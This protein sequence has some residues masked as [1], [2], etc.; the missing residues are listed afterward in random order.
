M[1]EH[2]NATWDAFQTH[3]NSKDVIHT[4]ISN[5]LPKAASDENTKLNA[6]KQH[7]KQGCIF[8]KEQQMNQ[9]Y[10]SNAELSDVNNIS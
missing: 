10:Q 9:L 6:V 4:N 2:S 8:H 7:I 3:V 5:F 1:I